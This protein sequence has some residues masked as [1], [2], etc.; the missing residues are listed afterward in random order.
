MPRFVSVLDQCA[1]Q[2][3]KVKDILAIREEKAWKVY[4]NVI[5]TQDLAYLFCQDMSAASS[6][7]AEDVN[8]CVKCDRKIAGHPPRT[9]GF[10]TKELN[11]LFRTKRAELKE[12]HKKHE[13]AFNKS[14]VE[15]GSS[16]KKICKV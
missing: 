3:L 2:M 14:T 4:K 9:C 15:M 10:V 11:E 6:I 1:G 7:A 13:P 12:N 8:L 5:P 16:L